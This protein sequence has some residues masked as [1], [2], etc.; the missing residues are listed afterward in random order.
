[1]GLR[2][3]S[4]HDSLITTISLSLLLFITSLRAASA[5]QLVEGHAFGSDPTA[6]T[7]S[8][9]TPSRRRLGWGNTANL[10]IS[11]GAHLAGSAASK[12][13]QSSNPCGTSNGATNPGSAARTTGSRDYSRHGGRR[14]AVASNRQ[15]PV[16]GRRQHSDVRLRRDDQAVTTIAVP[17]PAPAAVPLPFPLPVPLPLSAVPLSAS[18]VPLPS[19]AS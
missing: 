3:P 9:D 2:L 12:Q 4:R 5:D 7:E 19:A 15:D 10:L 14:D 18:Q 13:Q 17:L 6:F 8:L 16:D 1:M 11:A